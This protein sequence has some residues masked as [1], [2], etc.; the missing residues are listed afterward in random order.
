MPPINKSEP[1]LLVPK[2]T[3][4][5][6][7]APAA[8]ATTAKRTSR[9]VQRATTATGGSSGGAAA[10][11]RSAVTTD[12]TDA[13]KGP[14][15]CLPG[16]VLKTMPDGKRFCAKVRP[17]SEYA[18]PPWLRQ[19]AFTSDRQPARRGRADAR[20]ADSRQQQ[21]SSRARSPPPA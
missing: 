20:D 1:L 11:S 17:R 10:A 15:E 21:Q 9:I 14:R 5:A 16:R 13:S 8:T 19:Y 18:Q 2:A 4:A 3:T 12:L 7:A 6:S